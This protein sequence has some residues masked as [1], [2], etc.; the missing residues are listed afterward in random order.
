MSSASVLVAT[1]IIATYQFQ[2]KDNNCSC[3]VNGN[4]RTVNLNGNINDTIKGPIYYLAAATAGKNVYSD[5]LPF[6]NKEIAF[7]KTSNRGE[8]ITGKGGSF[9]I[10]MK[11]PNSYYLNEKT[12]NNMISPEVMLKY[13]NG[14]E[15]KV[16]RVKVAE[17]IPFRYQHY[18]PAREDIQYSFYKDGWTMPVRTQEQI[19]RDAEY[20]PTNTPYS[21]Y[22]GL[23][24]PM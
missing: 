4:R 16:I 23:K 21:N 1:S 15:E 18:P 10:T 2:H 9:N 17:P 12:D 22:W 19:I 3:I 6:P 13:N 11:T 14:K 5:G 20:P 24:P 7:S 8:I